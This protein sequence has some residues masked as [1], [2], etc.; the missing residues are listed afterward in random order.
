MALIRQDSGV[1]GVPSAGLRLLLRKASRTARRLSGKK[2]VEGFVDRV[3]AGEVLGWAFD[4]N[5]PTRRVHIVA[6][7]NGEIVAEALADLPR[8]DLA[9]GGKGDG[10]HGFNLRIPGQYLDGEARALRI[11]AAVGRSMVLLQGGAITLASRRPGLAAPAV[12]PAAPRVLQ[13]PG[14]LESVTD[15]VLSGWAAHPE[16]GAGPTLVDI[17]DDERYLGSATADRVRPKLQEAGAPAHAMGFQFRLPVPADAALLKRLRGRIA[18][19]GADLQPLRSNDGAASVRP[20][21]SGESADPA[22]SGRGRPRRALRAAPAEGRVA[23][24]IYGP[25]EADAVR[26]TAR[27]WTDQTWSDVAIGRL[28][29]GREVSSPAGENVFGGAD[30]GRLAEFL[31]QAR[32]VVLAAPGETLEPGAARLLA[33]ARPLADVLTWD[34]ADRSPGGVARRRSEAWPLAIQLGA[35][36]NGGVA[37]RWNAL[38]PLLLTRLDTLASGDAAALEEALAGNASLR[39]AHL[40]SILSSRASP[41]LGAGWRA[42]PPRPPQNHP[43]RISFA[44]WPRWS[45]AALQSLESLLAGVKDSEA[46]ILLP[47]EVASV[48]LERRLAALAPGAAVSIRPVDAP[49]IDRPGPWQRALSQAATGEVVVLCRAGVVVDAGEATASDLAAWAMSPLV[50]AVTCAIASG[51]QVLA[52][53]T[54]VFSRNGWRIVSAHDPAAAASSRPILA[55]SA[56][57]MAVERR[58]LAAVGGLNGDRLPD[59]GTGFDLGLRLRGAGWTSV[60]LAGRAASADPKLLRRDTGAALALCEPG[61][62]AAAAAAYPAQTEPRSRPAAD[63]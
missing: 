23:L 53:Q 36:L 60:L 30:A 45:D 16:P 44:V 43:R 28:A 19:A 40:P 59:G 39:W 27:S 4:P 9:Q 50:G 61:D 47:A 51:E 55:A 5:K 8:K 13:G 63:A 62:L 22:G 32:T 21:R 49:E 33:Q 46:E 35:A 20:S 2:P 1:A 58:K 17:Y 26:R 42:A 37:V 54:V 41:A 14:R 24:L 38:A 12:K 25:G 15:G 34:V 6:R 3:L 31:S 57:L 52:G 11:E 10:R 18:D 7:F 29:D 56:A 48:E